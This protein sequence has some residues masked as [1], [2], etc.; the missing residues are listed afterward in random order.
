MTFIPL[1]E[2][3]KTIARGFRKVPFFVFLDKGKITIQENTHRREKSTSFFEYF[4]TLGVDVLYIKNLGYNTFLKLYDMR[5]SV[6]LVQESKYYYYIKSNELLLLDTISAK[7]YC[8]M[9]HQ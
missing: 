7:T 6:Y 2:D 9:G 1:E 3:H 5:I 8:T 4:K